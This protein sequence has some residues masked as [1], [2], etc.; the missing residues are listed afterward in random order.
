MVP[1]EIPDLDRFES[2][3]ELPTALKTGQAASNTGDEWLNAVG[4]FVA[5][6]LEGLRKGADDESVYYSAFLCMLLSDG[7][8]F[9]SNFSGV[10]ATKKDLD[11]VD[12]AL[13]IGSKVA[14][15]TKHVL[16]SAIS[17]P[18]ELAGRVSK[19]AVEG[20]AIQLTL[21]KTKSPKFYNTR[22][23]AL[24]KAPVK[25]IAWHKYKQIFAISHRQDTVHLYDVTS[26]GI[27]L[28]STS[29]TC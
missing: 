10:K 18:L 12:T 14:G 6:F 9:P 27:N 20:Q 26:E 3:T 24:S 21:F 19:V 29:I 4:D 2:K 11:P 15:L 25:A 17:W 13:S 1:Y 22:L 23:E 5:S 16:E 7:R 8:V 28:K